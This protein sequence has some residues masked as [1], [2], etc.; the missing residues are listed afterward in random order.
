MHPDEC[1]LRVTETTIARRKFRKKS[2]AS[3]IVCHYVMNYE[4]NDFSNLH[5]LRVITH[6]SFY[7]TAF[8]AAS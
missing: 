4:I 1:A 3:S 5:L 6:T 7:L 2:P 8:N